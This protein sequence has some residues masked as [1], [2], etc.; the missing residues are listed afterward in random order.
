VPRGIRID[1]LLASLLVIGAGVATMA[2]KGLPLG[3]DFSRGTMVIA[4]F[5]EPGVTDDD[6]RAA[7]QP[8]NSIV[9]LSVNQTLSRTA[10]T[11]GTTL[12]SV[13]SLYIF[14][15]EALRGF[16]FTM[17]VGIVSGPYST[18]FIA[19]GIAPLLSQRRASAPARRDMESPARPG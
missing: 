13:L 6:V 5:T 9:N 2:T 12:L 7:G 18:V 17:L 8:L 11:A 1:A 10:L 3:I 19:S 4:E 15:G 14:G 16:A